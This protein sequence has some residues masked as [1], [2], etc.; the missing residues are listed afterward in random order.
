MLG[1]VFEKTILASSTSVIPWDHPTSQPAT[2]PCTC[3]PAPVPSSCADPRRL[4]A[5]VPPN[6]RGDSVRAQQPD[7]DRRTHA[8]GWSRLEAGS[9]HVSVS[10]RG[11]GRRGAIWGAQ[12]GN[13][14]GRAHVCVHT[15]ASRR[16][17]PALL[18]S[19][20]RPTEQKV[21]RRSGWGVVGTSGADV[22]AK[23][24]AGRHAV[25]TPESTIC[26]RVVEL[27]AGEGGREGEADWTTYPFR[28]SGRMECAWG[29]CASA[30]AQRFGRFA[31]AY[32]KED[33]AR[34]TRDGRYM[35]GA[36]RGQIGRSVG[37]TLANGLH[38]TGGAQSESG[39]MRPAGSGRGRADWKPYRCVKEAGPAQ[40]TA[41]G[42]E[43]VRGSAGLLRTER[44]ELEV[45]LSG[46]E[47]GA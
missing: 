39:A 45:P 33:G 24:G 43:A 35:A 3:G 36:G 37:G 2:A 27:S 7:A 26:A 16:L 12:P 41:R 44:A 5:R 31:M 34:G 23:L 40:R 21:P 18:A 32:R 30:A 28:N 10:S 20:V 9:A 47:G 42:V 17:Y 1:R 38:E 8:V 6:V 15:P 29:M 11:A 19:F 4:T 46:G 13:G 25:G 22:R 14:R